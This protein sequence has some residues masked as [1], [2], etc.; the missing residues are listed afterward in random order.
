MVSFDFK[1]VNEKQQENHNDMCKVGAKKRGNRNK[2]NKNS[3]EVQVLG[4]NVSDTNTYTKQ[5]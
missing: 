3:K 2:A 4:P 1:I 5:Q